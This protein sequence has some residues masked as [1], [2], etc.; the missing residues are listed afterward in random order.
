M[1]KTHTIAVLG[2]T[3]GLL[4]VSGAQAADQRLNSWSQVGEGPT[5]YFEQGGGDMAMP[6]EGARG[7]IRNDS[8][9]PL[10]ATLQTG[11]GPVIYFEQPTGSD[12]AMPKAGARGPIRTES[13]DRLNETLQA[14]EG[15]TIYDEASKLGH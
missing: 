14:G 1:K 7:P 2:S 15:P 10:N 6:N 11:E 3:L 4:L 13:M 12:M 8:M 5:I 9:E